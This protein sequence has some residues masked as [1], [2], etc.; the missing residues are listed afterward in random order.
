VTSCVGRDGRGLRRRLRHLL[1]GSPS[2]EAESASLAFGSAVSPRAAHHPASR[3]GSCL[4]LLFRGSPRKD[5]D[6]HWLFSFMVTSF[7]LATAV[8]CRLS[9]PRMPNDGRESKTHGRACRAANRPSFKYEYGV[10]NSAT[11]LSPLHRL[12]ICECVGLPPP[13]PRS[14]AL[15]KTKPA[16]WSA[17]INAKA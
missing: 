2:L 5:S 3:R 1:A 11:S 16:S 8:L 14:R 10:R 7:A 17:H 6:F 15:S 12:L 9:E 13:C 4:W